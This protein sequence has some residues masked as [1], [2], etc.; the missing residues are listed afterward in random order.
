MKI[1]WR[2]IFDVFYFIFVVFLVI[3]LVVVAYFLGFKKGEL[4]AIDELSS[5]LSQI[6][7]KQGESSSLSTNTPKPTLVVSPSL[8][9]K[10][11]SVDW[12]GPQLWE[13]VNKSRVENGV[14]PLKQADELCTIASIRLNELLELGKLDGHEGFSSLPERR[15]YLKWIFEKYNISEFLIA[16]A[17]SPQEAVDSWLDTLGHKK[18]LTGGEYVW[19]CTYAQNGFGVAI[20]AYQ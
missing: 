18:L 6:K 19:G 5:Y 11:K 12:T 1:N 15:P 3:S 20:A 8:L 7:P 9:P 13:A 17:A 10:K 4:V 2:I 14:N 16:G